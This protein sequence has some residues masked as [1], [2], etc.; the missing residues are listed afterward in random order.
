M[1]LLAVLLAVLAHPLS[2]SQART[3]QDGLK[4]AKDDKPLLVFC[5]GANFDRINTEIYERLFKSKDRSF[6]HVINKENYVVV[7][8]YQ[9]PTEAEKRITNK[10]MGSQRIPGGARSYPCIL[11]VDAQNRM[12]GAVQNAEDIETPEKAAAALSALLSDFRAQQKLLDQASRANGNAQDR[13]MREALAIS[14]VQVPGH[15]TYDPSNNGLVEDLQV[16]DDMSRANAHV[17]RIIANG[18]FTLI[19]RQMILV[20]LAG[21]MRRKGKV[22]MDRLGAL[23]TEIRNIDPKSIYGR[24]AEGALKIWV[25]PADNEPTE[26][27]AKKKST[28]VVPDKKSADETPADSDKE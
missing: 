11:L 24:Y 9:M 25:K 6:Y 5:Y 14:S 13:L 17:R 26:R 28:T 19:E 15:G 18:K 27:S 12:R 7:P 8:I 2:A 23:Y 22:S 3:Y 16:M 20:A 10:V 4:R 1:L 21:H